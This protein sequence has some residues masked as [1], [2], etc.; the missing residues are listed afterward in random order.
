MLLED[1]INHT[2]SIL[3]LFTDEFTSNVSISSI[4]KAASVVTVNTSSNHGLSVGD[5]ALVA[6]V[7]TNISMTTITTDIPTISSVTSSKTIATVTTA[8]NHYLKIGDKVQMSGADQT[9]YNLLGS[10]LAVT[11][12]TFSYRVYVTPVT[13]ATGTITGT[14]PD[15]ATA[16]CDADHDLT[17]GFQNRVEVT[18]AES[19][20]DG[21]KVLRDVPTS[22]VFRYDITGTASDSTG[23]LLTF[24]SADFNGV[25]TVASVVD[26]D[27]FTYSLSIDRLSSGSGDNMQVLKTPRITGTSDILRAID[28]YT[29]MSTDEIWGFFVFDGMTTSA[30]RNTNN[31]SV[32][33]LT[34]QDEVKI[35]LIHNFTFYLFIP[36]QSSLAMRDSIDKALNLAKPIYKTLVGYKPDSVFVSAQEPVVVPISHGPVDVDS[37]EL[38]PSTLIYGFDFQVQEFLVN[39]QACVTDVD[40]FLG[41]VGDVLTGQSTRAF[42]KLTWENVNDQNV[43]IKSDEIII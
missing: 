38:G 2:K 1:I 27:T 30:D 10:V 19:V 17:E 15:I 13:P 40:E 11:D 25:V 20:F 23:T 42:R 31:D 8:T 7:K 24:H 5:K 37:P 18:S 4:T 3:P 29:R 6:G 12:L 28:L 14:T 22:L 26:S 34:V 43:I 39:Q 41:N 9:E 32:V 16:T 33:E 21:T 36:S 35:R